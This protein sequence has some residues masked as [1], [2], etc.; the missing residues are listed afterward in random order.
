MCRR[1]AETFAKALAPTGIDRT[2]RQRLL[3]FGVP[4]VVDFGHHDDLELAN[5]DPLAAKNLLTLLRHVPL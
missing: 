4:S 2:P 5:V 1:R 3:R